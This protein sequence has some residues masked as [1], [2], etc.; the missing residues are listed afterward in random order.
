MAEFL[1]GASLTKRIREVVVGKDVRCAV[2][3]WGAH[4]FGEDLAR[5]GD[6]R[7]V[8]DIVGGSTSPKALES[9]G[10]PK[11]RSLKHI[12][13]L[14]SKVYI[15]NAG[16]VIGSANASA[17]GLGLDVNP[18]QLIEAGVFH[19]QGGH[20]WEQATKWFDN[21]YSQA[22]MVDKE[23][24]QLAAERYRPRT[25]NR[26]ADF[27]GMTVLEQIAADPDHFSHA[28]V[29]FII[30]R[31]NAD[32]N[33]IKVAAEESAKSGA[34]GDVSFEALLKHD[35][36]RT[37]I[38]WPHGE[39]ENLNA[40]FV[41]FYFGPNGGRPKVLAHILAHRFDNVTADNKGHF[42]TRDGTGLITLPNGSAFPTGTRK[43]LDEKDWNLL[44]RLAKDLPEPEEDGIFHASAFAQL[45]RRALQTNKD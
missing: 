11:N 44:V 10:A 5:R 22:S 34:G 28:G 35:P 27:N 26:I 25:A 17:N 32:D 24:L 38:G 43:S 7:I 9:L 37:F 40:K 3:Y 1:S 19:K 36:E 42:Y 23:A 33:E 8:C 12:D 15:S 21:L 39:M 20:L 4:G 13:N 29:G 41:E 31:T 2:A 18:A 30:C 14:H 6:V 45:L 16:V